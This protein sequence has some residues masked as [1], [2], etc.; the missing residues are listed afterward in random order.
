LHRRHHPDAPATSPVRI[1]RQHLDVYRCQIGVARAV[2]AAAVELLSVTVFGGTASVS[3]E[4]VRA[5]Q[6]S[7]P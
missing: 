5:F 3:A 1:D 2:G 4:L 6:L 7:L